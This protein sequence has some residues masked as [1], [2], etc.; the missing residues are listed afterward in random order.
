MASSDSSGSAGVPGGFGVFAGGGW[1]LAAIGGVVGPAAFVGAW[2]VG[3]ATK[4]GYSPVGDAI[5]RL[6]AVNASTRPRMTTGFVVF[7]IGVPIYATALRRALG[8]PACVTAAAAG[9]ATLGLAALPLER[10]AA[11]DTWHGAVAGVAYLALA[12]T[13]MLARRPLRE[14]GHRRLA[15]LSGLVAALTATSLALSL[16]GSATGLFQRIGLTTGDLWIIGSATAI[17]LARP[18]QVSS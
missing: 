17:L 1:R 9:L 15:A 12:A 6:A 2:V 11:V 14:R 10:S 13:P 3:S 5:S 16:T 7:G 8:G 18:G 4:A